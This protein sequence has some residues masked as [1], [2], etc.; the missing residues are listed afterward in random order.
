MYKFIAENIHSTTFKIKKTHD[1]YNFITHY[2]SVSTKKHFTF[3]PF[4]L[5]K[6]E[7]SSYIHHIFKSL[8]R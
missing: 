2:I 3:A 4:T 7:N 1:I 6:C 8:L 5:K